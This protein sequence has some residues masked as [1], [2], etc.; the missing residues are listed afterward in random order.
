MAR[1]NGTNLPISLKKSVEVARAIRGKTLSH[2][3]SYLEKVAEQKAVIPYVRFNQEM[4]H[5]KGKGISTG[6]YPV[7]VAEEFLRLVRNA[8]KNASDKELT[9]KLYVLSASARKGNNRYRMGRYIGRKMKST[10]AEVII[11]V[12]K[13]WLREKL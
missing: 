13:Q 4:P 3:V 8:E 5:K 12:K 7:K 9:G 6:G 1:A 2:A 10:N 11:G